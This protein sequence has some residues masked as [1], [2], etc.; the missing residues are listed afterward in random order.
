WCAYHRC[1][2]HDIEKCYK[3]K[4]LIE[5]LIREGHLKKLIDKGS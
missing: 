5:E 1:R 3:L 2:G 4:A